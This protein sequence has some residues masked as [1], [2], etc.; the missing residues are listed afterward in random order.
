MKTLKLH[1]GLLPVLAFF[2]F[3][4]QVIAQQEYVLLV[5]KTPDGE[6]VTANIVR[7]DNRIFGFFDYPAKRSVPFLLGG[8]AGENNQLKLT[9][10]DSENPLFTGF[11]NSENTLEG[12]IYLDGKQIPIRLDRTGDKESVENQVF[13]TT[14][15][16]PLNGEPGSPVAVFEAVIVLPKTAD[17]SRNE[18]IK[19]LIY[20]EFFKSTPELSPADL[21]KNMEQ[22]FIKFYSHSNEG[23]RVADNYQYMNWEKRKRMSVLHNARGIL[24]LHLSDYAYTGGTGGLDMQRFLVVD[25]ETGNKLSL[26]DVMLPGKMQLLNALIRD[27]ICR[28]LNI[29]YSDDLLSHGFFSNTTE[30]ASNFYFSDSG[31]CFHYNVYEIANAATGPVSV[32]LPYHSIR[33]LASQKYLPDVVMQE[34]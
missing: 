19:T 26:N 3:F 22:D 14:I 1:T 9:E 21:L 33:G 8:T 32:C 20:K 13:A 29:P 18:K 23:I 10:R 7:H 2:V 6:K 12:F 15:I 16:K 31:L 30:P 27:E 11:L 5:G 17:A 34:N 28:S 4:P 25:K 24:V